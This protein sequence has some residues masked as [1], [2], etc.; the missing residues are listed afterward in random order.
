MK[1]IRPESFARRLLA[2]KYGEAFV[3]DICEMYDEKA[4]AHGRI[5]ARIWLGFQLLLSIAA[6]VKKN[7]GG[8]T[9]MM[10]SYVL[11]TFRH[12]KKHKAYSLI[13]IF[14]LSAGLSVVIFILLFLWFERSYDR[15]HQ[16]ADR[17]YRISLKH[18][19]EGRFVED[20][21]IFTP[22][23]G[24]DMKNEFPEVEEY[25]RFSIPRNIY[26]VLENRA[27]KESDVRFADQSFFEFFSFRLTKGDPK[28]ALES[29][30]AIVL[31]ESCAERIFGHRDPTGAEVRI[32]Q[33]RTYIVT[34][35]AED[36]PENS[37]IQFSALIS[38]STLYRIPGIY[39][40]WNGGNQF[41]T[42]VK[43]S[44]DADPEAMESKFPDFLWSRI[45]EQIATVGWKY[46]AYLQPL[47]KIHFF[48]D[49]S[50]KTALTNFRTFSVTAMFILI[51]ACI[52]FI[53]LT[54]A[55]AARRAREV[56]L[57]KVVGAHRFH[58][59][60]Q[61]LGESIIMTA[62][63]FA[64]G[65]GFVV[66]LTP[67]YNQLL[68]KQMNVRE[69]L[70]AG[71][72]FWLL[73]L[74]LSVGIAA[75]I[76]P[77]FYLS[78][79]RPVKTLKGILVTGQAGKPFR[80]GL[81]ILQFTVSVGLIILTLLVQN[82]LRFIKKIELGYDK[83]NMVVVPLNQ[84]ELGKKTDILRSDLMAIPGIVQVAASS[85]VPYA[86]FTSNGYLPEGYTK[87]VMF[88]ALDV[89]ENFLST[90]GIDVVE[91][92]NF[93]ENF[94][95]DEEAVLINET[96]ARQVGWTNPLG[97][98][99]HR[100]RDMRVIGIVKD[101]QFATLHDTIGPLI[102]SHRPW[103]NRFGYLS[104]K[105]RSSDIRQTLDAVEGIFKEISPMI[106]FEYFFLDDAFNRMYKSEERFQKIFAYFAGLAVCIALLGLFSLSAYSVQQKAKEIGIRKVLG[107]SLP[108]LLSLLSREIILLV[109]AANAVAWP[110]AYIFMK[111]WLT[112]FSYKETI[113]I[114]VFSAALV[115][116]LCAALMTIGFQTLKVV[117]K[118]PIEDLRAE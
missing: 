79:F 58:L 84:D 37:T 75:G 82:Q 11:T 116:S 111:K 46:E 88:Y 69:L 15:F 53:N 47:K 104:I 7:I 9:G 35:V 19:C 51:I 113:S 42:Y 98:I 54:T 99:I 108:N 17:I 33:D 18:F 27:H 60:K 74:A 101:F 28:T 8:S 90:Y 16:D 21:H 26:L 64:I 55:R 117:L 81:V 114:W 31:T 72:I 6:L 12:F 45:N 67:V 43:L 41:I 106:L 92:R 32:G 5:N 63:A 13:N 103:D 61:F 30:F 62:I 56:G 109:I 34:G 22:P 96:L 71:R 115:G 66:I 25:A 39:M 112:N 100:N 1:K 14:G 59:I 94:A 89:D 50:S 10:K 102:I 107:A 4:A 80:K 3:G 118:D 77:A 87:S 38:F 68:D 24:P 52:N 85:D 65:V 83:E 86:G 44:A 48:Y 97:K 2:E 29:P 78:S 23:I 70:D 57:R 36:P 49:E 110:S 95:T 91:G 73:V 93:S 20:S 76:Y 40:D 105:I